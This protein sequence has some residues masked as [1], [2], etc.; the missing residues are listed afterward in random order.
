MYTSVDEKLRFEVMISELCSAFVNVPAGEVD[1]EIDR[2]LA[3]IVKYL[4]VDRGTLFQISDDHTSSLLTHTWAANKSLALNKGVVADLSEAIAAL[5][6]AVEKLLRREPVVFSSVEDLPEEASFDRQYFETQ[7]TRSLVTMPLAVAGKVIGAV[8]FSATLREI[9]WSEELIRRLQMVAHVFASAISRKRSDIEHKY[10]IDRYQTLFETA[11]DGIL[12]LGQERIADCN[13]R[14]IAMFGCRLKSELIDQTLWQFS[15]PFQADGR[16]SHDRMKRLLELAAHGIPQKFFWQYRRMDESLFEAEVALSA[17]RVS[18]EILVLAI[19]RDITVHVETE[20]SLKETN[21]RLQAERALLGEK[22]A[23]L[24]A[25]LTQLEQQRIEFE[26]RVC[27][28]LEHMFAPYLQKL[29]S[30]NGRLNNRELAE[31][32]DAFESIVGKGVNTFKE[33]Y[34][35]LS[36]R[37]AEICELIAKGLSS[38]EI[39]EALNVAPQTVHKHRETIRRKLRIQNLEI[40]LS[41]YLRNKN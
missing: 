10:A 4:G 35:K 19:V 21:E 22:N 7:G 32:E 29:R 40:N 26:E 38:K 3:F 34:A 23:A 13:G 25:I 12:V 9:H 27:S 6:W 14:S 33:N 8:A 37:E 18:R 15:P 11:S 2:W 24:R 1:M 36:P 5:P 16:P 31:L 41:T 17:L 30:G 20:N 39:S 28:S